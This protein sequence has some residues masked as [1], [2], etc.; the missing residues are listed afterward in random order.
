M[1]R[2]FSKLAVIALLMS[3]ITSQAKADTQWRTPFKGSS[4]AVAHQHVETTLTK[5]KMARATLQATKK[6]R[7]N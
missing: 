3:G 5:V 7:A 4:Y 1:N 6:V 2:T